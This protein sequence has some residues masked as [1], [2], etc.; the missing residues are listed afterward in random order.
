LSDKKKI[1]SIAI[2]GCEVNG[3]GEA[4]H[5]DMGIAGARNGEFIL[6]AGG[7]PLRRIKENEII[8]ALSA[9]TAKLIS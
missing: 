4:S 6:F 9:E 5:A 7:E 3:P 1:I 8:E 2:M